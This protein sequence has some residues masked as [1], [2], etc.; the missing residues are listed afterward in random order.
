MECAIVPYPGKRTY[1]KSE[2]IFFEIKLFRESASHELFLEMILPAIEEAGYRVDPRWNRLNGLWGH[3]DVDSIYVAAGSQ[4]QPLVRQGRLDLRCHPTSWQWEEGISDYTTIDNSVIWPIFRHV[5]WLT[6]FDLGG[7][8]NTID[9]E[10][11]NNRTLTRI[12]E[13]MIVRLNHLLGHPSA[14]SLGVWDFLDNEQRQWL[15]ISM[16]NGESFIHG[17]HDLEPSPRSWPGRWTGVQ[18]FP[19]IPYMFYHYL[20]LASIIHIGRQTQLGCG[21]FLLK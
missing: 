7:E 13:A 12:V 4:W 8:K 17:F 9:P 20:D 2:L 10:D 19:S 16:I 15:E 3:Y 14:H 1:G 18:H 5:R 11:T 21:T 6:P